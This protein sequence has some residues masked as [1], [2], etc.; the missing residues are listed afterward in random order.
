MDF[1]TIGVGVAAFTLV[2]IALVVILMAAK[3]RLV[4]SGDVRILI[5]GDPDKALTTQA[6]STLLST[7]AGNQIFIPSACGGQ[8]TC[9]VC[10]V[11][12]LEGGGSILPT[13]ESHINKREAR[14]GDRL[15]CQVAVKQDMKIQVP[16]HV[17][18]VKKW[19]CKVRSNHNVATF[20]KEL[21]LELP[22]GEHV[23]FRAGGYIKIECPPYE[24]S[25]KEFDVEPEYH[26]DWDRFKIW[27]VTSK[28]DEAVERAY[29][30]ANYP[31]EKGIIMLNVRIATPPPDKP[32]AP[33][34]AWA[35]PK[36]TATPRAGK[37]PR[38]GKTPP[39]SPVVWR[40]SPSRMPRFWRP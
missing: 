11:K 24:L 10:R 21:V 3:S 18:G 12:V 33:P 20:I 31:D 23:N 2:I 35:R 15:S 9:G 22:E 27:D 34:G 4:Q 30:M 8:G 36:P 40:R 16:E 14:E 28:V 6:G 19:R 7:L 13:E 17:F 1:F 38:R 32:S 39:G 37:P 5:N 29:S 26:P 25:Y